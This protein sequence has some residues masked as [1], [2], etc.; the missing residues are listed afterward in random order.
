MGIVFYRYSYITIM[1]DNHKCRNTTVVAIIVALVILLTAIIAFNRY[2]S[3]TIERLDDNGRFAD[4]PS[5]Y[6]LNG[7]SCIPDNSGSVRQQCNEGGDA[8]NEGI[9]EYKTAATCP[10][11]MR[12]MFKYCKDF[13]TNKIAPISSATCTSP[14]MVKSGAYCIKRYTGTCPPY[15]TNTK[16]GANACVQ[17][18]PKIS[19]NCKEGETLN[20]GRCTKKSAEAFVRANMIEAEALRSLRFNN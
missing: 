7:S 18:S 11:D 19:P 6:V 3:L 5:G 13:N 16:Q 9:C 17:A 4:C 2:E 12:N 1:S 15:Y 8:L 20:E 14:E 10:G